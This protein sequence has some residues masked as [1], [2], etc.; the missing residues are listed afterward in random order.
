MD[1]VVS[2]LVFRVHEGCDAS[3]LLDEGPN[4]EKK[5]PQNR[6]LGG[7]ALIDNIKTVLES[8][9]PGIVSCADILHLAARDAAKMAGAPGYPVF[10]GRKDGMKSDAASVDLPSPSISWQES[11]AYF[12]S[13]GLDVLDMTTLLG[14][15]TL[16]QTHCSFIL[17]RLYNFNGTGNS[18]PSLDATFRDKL[19]GLCPPKTKKGQH[20]P[21]VFLNPES[22][23]NYIFR[24]SYYKRI[25]RNEAVLG[26]DQ[27][28]LYGDDTK[29]ITDEF[30]AGF[31]D[32]RREFAHSMF[33]MGNIKVLTG[34]QGEIRRNCRFTNK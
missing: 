16:G 9:C 30:A 31:E 15:H 5:A 4:P 32:F 25:L 33:K 13:R 17:D 14:A 27:Q 21:L 19:R 6:G 12:K 22:G 7:F 20:D 1:S 28:L 23:S 11:L 18:D 26:I 8:R 29:E 34:N 2:F 3:I 24:E 10:T